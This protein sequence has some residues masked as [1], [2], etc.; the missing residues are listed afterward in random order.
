MQRLREKA[1]W[2]EASGWMTCAR[3]KLQSGQ[4]EMGRNGTG[5][6]AEAER[7][8]QRKRKMK[9]RIYDKK[10]I[11]FTSEL[12]LSRASWIK[13]LMRDMNPLL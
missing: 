3:T 11:I 9:E 13:S 7:K 2:T 4:K 8:K 12:K 6:L 5:Q 10:S 1:H